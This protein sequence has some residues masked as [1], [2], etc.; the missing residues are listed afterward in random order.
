MAPPHSARHRLLLPQPVPLLS[1]FFFFKWKTVFMSKVKK[2]WRGDIHSSAT[3]KQKLF[4]VYVSSQ[5][6]CTR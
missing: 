6:L 2:N 3:L 5:L 4:C 1:E